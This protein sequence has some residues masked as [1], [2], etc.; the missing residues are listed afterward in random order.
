ML[1]VVTYSTSALLIN[2]I[3][4][5]FFPNFEPFVFE[6]ST[7]ALGIIWSG[8]LAA[9]FGSDEAAANL[10]KAAFEVAFFITITVRNRAN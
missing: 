6:I 8:I 1:A 10:V 3:G 4:P 9:L 5:K 7:Y 2:Y